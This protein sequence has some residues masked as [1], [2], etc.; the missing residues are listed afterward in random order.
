MRQKLNENP[1]LQVAVVAVL[2]VLAGVFLLSSMG[3]GEEGESAGTT[4]S[5]SVSTPSGSAT[6]T[7]T[8]STSGV[9]A[10]GAVAPT[11][12]PTTAPAPPAPP[13]P[14]KIL[15]AYAS[16]HTV[17]LLIVDPGAIDDALTAAGTLPLAFRREVALFVVP[18]GRVA[19]YA[20]I[21][22]GVDVNRVPALVVVRPR[23]SSASGRGKAVASV[24]YG[25]QSA[26]SIEQAV[27]DA[28]YRGRTLAYHP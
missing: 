20:A 13:L 15:G 26:E 23:G 17:V 5:A 27:I 3:G 14:P 24:S 19:R 16:G 1:L 8:V 28:G 7:A 22:Q 18:V 6:V 9:G 4:S 21:T 11:A 12:S 25:F 2:L 10:T